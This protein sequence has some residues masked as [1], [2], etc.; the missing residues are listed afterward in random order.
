MDLS[1]SVSFHLNLSSCVSL[2]HFASDDVGFMGFFAQ[3]LRLFA[4]FTALCTSLLLVFTDLRL[5][6]FVRYT[7]LFSLHL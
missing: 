4:H 7:Y 6:F 1:P 2:V 5:L 3:S